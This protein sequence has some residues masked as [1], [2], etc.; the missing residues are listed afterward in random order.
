[1]AAHG[2]RGAAVR[3]LL[4]TSLQLAD[5]GFSWHTQRENWIAIACDAGLLAGSIGKIANDIAL[6]TQFEIS[7]LA[8]PAAAG[9]GG[10]SAMPHKRNPVLCLRALAAVQAVP[11]LVAQL[12]TAMKQ[13]H[14]RAL[15][16]WQ[17]ELAAWPR[18][19]VHT[20]SAAAALAP[21]LEGLQVNAARCQENID[22]LH[23]VLFADRLAQ[24]F[25]EGIGKL[26]AHD[27]VADLSRR[28][29]DEQRPL[30][31]LATAH[32]ASDARL[33][34]IGTEKIAA[35]FDQSNAVHASVRTAESLLNAMS[36]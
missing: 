18:V 36:Q 19:F 33:V 17:A 5:T 11:H 32:I 29:I 10:S 25:A 9:R 28:A 30:A 1:L 22:Q 20:Y 6:M 12:L 21:L 7:E 8:E 34:T 4:A 16:N 27:L 13:E 2:E 14:E 23:G 35:C 31:E 15:G 3:A 24:L 26:E